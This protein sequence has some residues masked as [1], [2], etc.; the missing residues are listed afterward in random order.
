MLVAVSVHV[1]YAIT[2]NND[3]FESLFGWDAGEEL[4]DR[5]CECCFMLTCSLCADEH[6]ICQVSCEC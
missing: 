4:V 3:R 5:G 6:R 1:G 2:A